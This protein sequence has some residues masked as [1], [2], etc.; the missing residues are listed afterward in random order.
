M[1]PVG[2]DPGGLAPFGSGRVDH[3]RL[4]KALRAEFSGKGP[5]LAEFQH[6]LILKAMNLDPTG[7]TTAYRWASDL[8]DI[9]RTPVRRGPGPTDGDW[10]DVPVVVLTG[11]PLD[12]DLDDVAQALADAVAGGEMSAEV[13]VLAVLPGA[14]GVWEIM[15][16]SQRYRMIPRNGTFFVALR[17]R[18]GVSPRRARKAAERAWKA[19]L[20]QRFG[21]RA[22]QGPA[23]ATVTAH[24]FEIGYRAAVSYRSSRT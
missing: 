22:E 4:R 9:V 17:V 18:P 5:V 15:R 13:G 23:F 20:R 2:T 24:Q 3:D 16:E 19:T 11:L 10:Q 6:R 7:L 21:V 8:P 14:A 1:W 12:T